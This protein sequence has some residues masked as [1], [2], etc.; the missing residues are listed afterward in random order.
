MI[1]EY[2]QT[3]K[4]TC[5]QQASGDPFCHEATS[6]VDHLFDM[7]WLESDDIPQRDQVHTLIPDT[8]LEGTQTRSDN[9]DQVR[10][11]QLQ[12]SVYCIISL[13]SDAKLLYL[14]RECITQRTVNTPNACDCQ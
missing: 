13:C 14:Q 2:H 4:C 11:C 12:G 6:P 5:V 1:T 10:Q 7:V 3:S 9:P 8:S